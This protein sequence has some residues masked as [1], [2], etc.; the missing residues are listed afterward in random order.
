[1]NKKL[2]YIISIEICLVDRIKLRSNQLPRY[3]HTAVIVDGMMIV[4]GGNT[5]NDTSISLGA[6][7]Y[8]PDLLLYDIRK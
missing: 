1:M 7:C 5:H 3:L 8:S 4:Y 6:K 2:V